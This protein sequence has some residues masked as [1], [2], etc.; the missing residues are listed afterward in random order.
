MGPLRGG[1][2]TTREPIVPTCHL[3]TQVAAR[4]PRDMPDGAEASCMR[5][6]AALRRLLYLQG[7]GHLPHRPSCPTQTIVPT[8]TTPPPLR[9]RWA[10]ETTVKSGGCCC[11]C[12]WRVHAGTAT[13]LGSEAAV[14]THQWLQCQCHL[15][16]CP[17]CPG[18]V[19]PGVA[20]QMCHFLTD[21]YS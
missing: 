6:K 4:T 18:A 12:R 13:V 8:D 15:A 5:L 2:T 1:A 11:G 21:A 19:H 10:S 3:D 17:S 20:C 7:H 14:G 16:H 9:L